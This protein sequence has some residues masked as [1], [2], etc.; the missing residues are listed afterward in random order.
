VNSLFFFSLSFIIQQQQ[1]NRQKPVLIDA[2]ENEIKSW[3][4]LFF[5]RI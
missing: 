3:A 1:K 5:S 4:L 2:R